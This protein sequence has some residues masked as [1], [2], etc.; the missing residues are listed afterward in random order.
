[1]CRITTNFRCILYRLRGDF[2]P[3]F[4]P[5]H[6]SLSCRLPLQPARPQSICGPSTYAFWVPGDGAMLQRL[7][8]YIKRCFFRKCHG[9][10][11]KSTATVLSGSIAMTFVLTL[12][13]LMRILSL[14][15][16]SIGSLPTLR[17]LSSCVVL[18]LNPRGYNFH[19]ESI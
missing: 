1:M 9:R 7:E 2:S 16:L 4:L 14:L 10:Y 3:R 12:S 6:L 11:L 19:R 17:L 13:W 15:E 5:M 18:C 8:R